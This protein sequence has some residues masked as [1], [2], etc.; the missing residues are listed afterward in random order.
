MRSNRRRLAVLGAGV[1]AV[2]AAAAVVLAPAG[3]APAAGPQGLTAYQRQLQAQVQH[4]DGAPKAGRDPARQRHVSLAEAAGRPNPGPARPATGRGTPVTS[5][6][7]ADAT[8]KDPRTT[9][10]LSSG[11]VTGYGTAGQCVPARAPGN[12]PMTCGYLHTQFEGGVAV[13]GRDRLG[14][15][16]NRDGLACADGDRGVPAGTHA[17]P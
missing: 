13:T 10:V 6:R 11:C 5:G 14:L 17:H 16:T 8:L 3:A 1:A 15:D 9:G 12:R 2:A 7:G 4:P